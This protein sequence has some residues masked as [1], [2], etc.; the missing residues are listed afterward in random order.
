MDKK[1][2]KQIKWPRPMQAVGYTLLCMLASGVLTGVLYAYN[3]GLEK[4]IAKIF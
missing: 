4:V 3:M 1:I 2:I